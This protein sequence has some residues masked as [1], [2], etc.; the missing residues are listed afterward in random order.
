MQSTFTGDSDV[1]K[2]MAV[3]AC[4][5]MAILYVAILY[6]PTL[7]LCLPPSDSF[8]SYMIRRFICAA[9]SSVFSLIA[10]SL[11]LPIQWGKSHV[12]SIY[13]IRLDHIWQ[14]VVFPLALT[15]LMYAGTL[16]LNLLLLL[17]SGQEDRENGRSLSL[18]SIKNLVHGFIEPISS[19][20]SNIQAWRNYL[21]APLTEELVF[22]ACMI[23]LLLCGGFSTYTVVFLCPIFFSLAHLNHLLEQAQRSGSWLKALTIVGFQ[24]GYT[25]IFGSY[26]SFLFVRTGHL[27][28]PLVA[29]IFCNYLGLPVIISRRTGMVTVA[30]VAGLLGFIWLLFPLTSPHLYNAKTD[31]CMCWHRYCSWS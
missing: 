27:T 28:A 15:S 2:S 6:A 31:N 9:I 11:I 19:M 12:S 3:I 30:S 8:Q 5:A 29:H 16:I 17:D 13:G 25:V 10:C 20:A 26:A 4:T 18:D 7:I 1:S 24:V 14:A 22:R 21:V 23:P